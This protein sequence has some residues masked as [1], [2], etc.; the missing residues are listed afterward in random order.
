MT[1]RMAIMLI[2]VAVVF[3]GIFG[4][5]AF[6]A[7]MIR[8]FM[9]SQSAP[10]QTVSATKA[11]YSEW[12]PTIEAVGSLRAVKGADL[13]LEVSG[14][15]DSIS[16]NS[17]DDVGKGALLLKLRA[18]DDSAKLRSLQAVE[19]LNEITYRRDQEQFK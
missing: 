9:S 10:P 19:Q 7:A 16:F 11:E 8:K 2:A 3:G 18:D 13:S 15:V 5:Q 6:K 4:F 17:G 12:Q 14:V 1:K